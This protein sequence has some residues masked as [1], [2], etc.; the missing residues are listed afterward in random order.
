MDQLAHFI[1]SLDP[2]AYIG[3]ALA[4]VIVGGFAGGMIF[5]VKITLRR[6]AYLWFLAGI[7]LALSVSQL[8]WV[9]L[10]SALDGNYPGELLL[11]MMACL[12]L[13]GIA[14]YYGAAARS[15]HI[16]GTTKQAWM[17]FVPFVN[18][19]LMFARGNTNPGT[20]APPVSGWRRWVFDPALVIVGVLVLALGNALSS[21]IDERDV[22]AEADALNRYISRSLPVQ[23]S[24]A[25]KALIYDAE[26]PMRVDEITVL[27]EVST[28]GDTL[29]MIYD[30]EEDIG[31]FPSDFD[32]TLASQLCRISVFGADIA[33]GGKIAIVYYAPNGRAV[34]EFLIAQDD[35]VS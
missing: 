4:L 5:T 24:L 1:L 14:T 20:I 23:D 33:R 7:N 32:Q 21:A 30:I 31:R 13:Y 6:V 26:L 15:N 35:C 11:A 12:F 28:K 17:G 10:P 16:D 2:I 29:H 27:K 8:G 34:G 22:D 9:A 25:R 18:L 3:F 19:Y